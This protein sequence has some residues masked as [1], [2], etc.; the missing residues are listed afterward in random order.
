M[1]LGAKIFIFIGETGSGKSTMINAWANYYFGVDLKDEFRVR[2]VQEDESTS[3]TESQTKKI[4]TYYLPR[5]KLHKAVVLV[6]SP[7]FNDTQ[8][9]DE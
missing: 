7:G 8:G 4:N 3:Q 5:T 9:K 6:D 1:A 2:L